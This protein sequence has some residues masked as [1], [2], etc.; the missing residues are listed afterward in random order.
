[1][2]EELFYANGINA[3]T[4]TY[5][6]EPMTP[7]Q[8]TALLKDNPPDKNN[9]HFL[10]L[11]DKWDRSPRNPEND[12]PEPSRPAGFL[13]TGAEQAEQKPRPRGFLG[14][15]AGVDPK[16]LDQS[17]WGVIFADGIDSRV[18]GA[19]GGLLKLR[20]QQAG[21]RYREY[22]LT[23]RNKEQFMKDYQAGSGP[24]DPSKIPYYLLLVGDPSQIPY[25]FQYQMDVQYAV[26]RIAFDTLEEY[27]RY[28]QSVVD[29]EQGKVVLPRQATF[30]GVRNEDDQATIM[31][32]DNLVAPLAQ[33][34]QQMVQQEPQKF[35]SWTTQVL[36]KEQTKRAALEQVL[37]GA[38]TP[39]L[40]FTA[41]HGMAFPK[42]H[43]NQF[44]HQGALLCQDWPGPNQW[45][46]NKIISEDYYF[47]GNHIASDARLLGLIAFFFACYGAGTP[48]TDEFARKSVTQVIKKDIASRPF[49]S[50]LPRRMLT[51]PNGGALAVVGHVERAWAYSFMGDQM[52]RNAEIEVFRSTLYRLLEG[53]PIG[54]AVEYFNERYA[55]ISTAL[56]L[57]VFKE[58]DF[59]KTDTREF[60]WLWTANNDARNYAIIGDPAVRL[61]VGDRLPQGGR[62]TIALKQTTTTP[63]AGQPVAPPP[64][65]SSSAP[66]A[67]S[68]GA[69]ATSFSVTGG[70][71]AVPSLS[72]TRVINCWIDGYPNGTPVLVGNAYE[73]KLNVDVPYA[74]ALATSSDMGA[75][76][77]AA[78]QHDLEIAIVLETPDAVIYGDTDHLLFV[79]REGA[80]K[81]TAIFTIEPSH[82]GDI[83]LVA[84]CLVQGQPLT[85]IPVVLSAIAPA[86]GSGVLGPPIPRGVEDTTQELFIPSPPPQVKGI[87]EIDEEDIT[88][89]LQGGAFALPG[90]TEGDGPESL[91]A[92][93]ERVIRVGME[94]RGT[95]VKKTDRLQRNKTYDLK[96]NVGL[97]QA[98]DIARSGSIETAMSQMAAE[99]ATATILIVLDSSD[100]TIYG[101][102]EQTIIVPRVGPSKNTATFTIEPVKDGKGT[103]TA[104]CF[105]NGEVFQ[106]V[107]LTLFT[108]EQDGDTQ[109]A[110]D[111]TFRGRTLGSVMVQPVYQK[112][113]TLS[114]IIQPE[115]SGYSCILNNG[116]VSR[117]HLRL[118]QTKIAELIRFARTTFE[119]VTTTASGGVFVYVQD[120]TTIPQDVYASSLAKLAKLGAYLF[121]QLFYDGQGA[122]ARAI[123]D[124]L[125][126]YSQQQRLN[127]Q[128]V[129]QDFIFPWA[130]LYDRTPPPRGGT[131]VEP[132][133]FWG[134]K[135]IIEYK[136]EFTAST[137]VNFDP[138]IAIDETMTLGFVYN[139]TIDA[140]MSAPLIADQ[141][142][143][144]PTLPGVKV[145]EYAT[146]SDLYELLRT[147]D[148]PEQLLYFYCH[149]TG[150]Q[151]DE[152]G[153]VQSSCIELS[154]AAAM[155]SDLKMN[156]PASEPPL[157]RAPLVFVNACQSARMSPYLYDGLVPY[158]LNRGARG[159]IGT[160]VNTPAH[161][162]AEFA[163]TFFEQFTAGGKPLGE[164]LRDL[165]YHYVREKRN[166][167]GLLYALYSSGDVMIV[168]G[169]QL[170][171]AAFDTAAARPAPA[172]LPT[173]T[174]PAVAAQPA[175]ATRVPTQPPAH[176]ATPGTLDFWPGSN[177]ERQNEET[178]Q[179][180]IFEQIAE[181]LT[182][183]LQSLAN[184]ISETTMQLIKDVALLSVETYVSDEDGI[185]PNIKASAKLRAV[186]HIKLDGDVL[187]CVP[188]KEGEVDEKLMRIHRETV[189][190]AQ[191]HRTEMVKTL[192]SAAAELFKVIK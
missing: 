123:G 53:H 139:T 46:K 187:E 23:G 171:Q 84:H 88:S 120:D 82:A 34:V 189:E 109:Q 105:F 38:Q 154:D 157:K 30:F 128:V 29:A 172:P 151:P 36:L 138:V 31:S 41:S 4:G 122:D 6:I 17:G 129:A 142:M 115:V 166:V 125:R 178:A 9:P 152:P 169:G 56:A 90:A 73:L 156:A 147:T 177:N 94:D 168:R 59:G 91:P 133:G 185:S 19:L 24:V 74:H 71:G 44:P 35:G 106:Q 135:H 64:P 132:E 26:G 116:G 112:A 60:A 98:E 184:K 65:A 163:R 175:T 160:E 86:A 131:T 47:A 3:V 148:A 150:N 114:L 108:G 130:L 16:K 49:L 191:R 18:P 124:F 155:I 10:A 183:N 100:F 33:K 45:P 162:A 79:P 50:E 102:K 14:P 48:V 153:G 12:V 75:A 104:S 32:A 117:A 39:S 81:N 137:L 63:V 85:D 15:A 144:F 40:L 72:A 192:I 89:G 113:K 103:I 119:Q 140:Q 141:R 158:L 70:A 126:D 54:S 180:S 28:A 101:K 167:M 76:T 149:A 188:M 118:S 107:S 67:G 43:P 87:E 111:A 78:G 22:Y 93:A 143:F 174:V 13:G 21:E 37:G 99:R 134:F 182:T 92:P 159:V 145:N 136:P 52:A 97:P 146:T 2:S 1:M 5:D 55:E 181:D 66:P 42:D 7:E 57:R 121:D 173:V 127:V 20:K 77:A 27:E 170:A 179:P 61:P 58:L 68:G 83:T 8:F 51:H 110:A 164:L 186:T 95:V 190:S 62:P 69:A 96:F 165:R 176:G 80:S 25:E 161:F 11:K